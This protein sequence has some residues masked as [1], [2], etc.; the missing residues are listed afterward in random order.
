VARL[1][2]DS[3]LSVLVSSP[4]VLSSSSILHFFLVLLAVDLRFKNVGPKA[5]GVLELISL[6]SPFGPGCC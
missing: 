3:W 6:F 5:G 4:W 1:C 2:R